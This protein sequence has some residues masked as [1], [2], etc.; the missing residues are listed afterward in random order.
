M[1]HSIISNLNWRY[2]T[3]RY[4]L[5]QI[6]PD[7]T[8][9]LIKEALRLTPTS[10]GLQPLKFLLIKN[11]EIRK[12]LLNYSY[13]QQSITD[14]SHLI[15]IASYKDIQSN[16]IDQ[17]MQNTALTRDLPLE[18]L[19]G[20][21]DFLKRIMNNQT[22]EQKMMWAQKQAYITLGVLVDICAQLK[23]DATPIEGFDAKGYDNILNLEEKGLTSTIVVPIGYRH[24][25]DVTQHWKKVRKTAEELFETY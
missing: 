6:I 9:D 7:Q 15:V 2:A 21:S 14:A 25:D 11:Q 12:Q 24:N 8:I 10:Y 19:S 4:D 20:Y 22:T 3:K 17:Y 1:N 18:Q 5:T 13:N 16:E 23:V